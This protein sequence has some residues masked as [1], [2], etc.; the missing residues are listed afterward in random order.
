[1]LLYKTLV[2]KS[3]KMFSRNYKL[4]SSVL[5]HEKFNL[6][7][8]FFEKINN[9]STQRKCQS[10][11]E[12]KDPFN[13]ESQLSSDE[14]LIR[15]QFRS[16]CTS[17]LMPRVLMANRNEVFHPEIIPEMGSLGVLGCTIKGYGCAGVSSVAY[18]LLAREIERVDSGYRSTMSVQSSLV[19]HPIYAYGTEQQRTKYLPKLARGELIGM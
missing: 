15:D 11:F 6:K 17:K 12:W 2:S 3:N 5:N 7:N 14:I 4:C 1:M 16:Y 8:N 9:F 10:K 19:M 13:L 18:G